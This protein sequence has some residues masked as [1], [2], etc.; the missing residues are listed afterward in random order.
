[1][2]HVIIGHGEPWP[3]YWDLVVAV[4]RELFRRPDADATI[5]E[6]VFALL[7][8]LAA[9]IGAGDGA[10]TARHAITASPAFARLSA[11][12][13]R[14]NW[15][16]LYIALHELFPTPRREEVEPTDR[17]DVAMLVIDIVDSTGLVNQI[18]TAAFVD[19]LSRLRSVLRASTGLRFS[20][21]TGDGFLA[22]YAT[23]A[24]ALEAARA[25]RQVVEAPV[26]LRLVIH[27]GPVQM[28]DQDVH[29]MEVN[30][31]FRIESVVKEHAR[32][33]EP[34]SGLALPLPGRVVISEP[35]LAALPEAA[36]A[37]FRRAGAFRLKGFDEPEALWVEASV[38]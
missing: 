35:A 28:S 31:T 7:D 18:G 17:V 20:K 33:G 34:G 37:G 32:A 16:E 21:G 27:R 4:Q 22:V 13:D 11:E 9:C 25:L 12:L 23:V 30:R 2:R 29:G 38:G 19:H 15:V 24:R 6:A 5:G 8:R 26:A 10:D 14:V 1:M 36:R 3:R